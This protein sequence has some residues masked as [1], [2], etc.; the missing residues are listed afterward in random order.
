MPLTAALIHEHYHITHETAEIARDMAPLV[1]GIIDDR[2]GLTDADIEELRKSGVTADFN[3]IKNNSVARSVVLANLA[4]KA[5]DKFN[6]FTEH[7]FESHSAMIRKVLGG[8]Q[9]NPRVGEEFV[10]RLAAGGDSRIGEITVQQAEVLL[11][12]IKNG[13]VTGFSDIE[14]AV[15][16]IPIA[17]LA[18]YFHDYIQQEARLLPDEERRDFENAWI[19]LSRYAQ[20]WRMIQAKHEQAT[21]DAINE[22]N[23]F[24]RAHPR[25]KYEDYNGYGRMDPQDV[26]AFD[27]LLESRPFPER[28]QPRHRRH[29]RR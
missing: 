21:V 1:N 22:I 14:K 13:D 6:R 20:E 26:S 9:W 24:H 7:L 5:P 27:P 17:H 15:G 8:V 28:T 11:D 10:T 23:P 4:S 12:R 16:K 29:L 3:A 19:D 2:G 25:G 18:D